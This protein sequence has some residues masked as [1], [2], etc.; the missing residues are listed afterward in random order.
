VKKVHVQYY[1]V[2][3]EERGLPSE[4]LS[5]TAQTMRDLYAELRSQHGFSLNTDRLGVAVN[6]EFTSWDQLLKDSDQIVFVPP[7][8]GG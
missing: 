3:R 8:A 7:V 4:T 5:T 6:D 2:L 1:A